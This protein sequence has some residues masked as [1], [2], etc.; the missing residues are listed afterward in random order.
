MVKNYPKT[1]VGQIKTAMTE[2]VNC[3]ENKLNERE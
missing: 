1:K 2:K 3:D